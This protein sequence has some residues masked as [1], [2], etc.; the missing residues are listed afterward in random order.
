MIRNNQL[1]MVTDLD[2]S[3]KCIYT[4]C[5][6]VL[7]IVNIIMFEILFKKKIYIV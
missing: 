5:I 2:D 6:G 7:Y 1:T 4:V 3:Y